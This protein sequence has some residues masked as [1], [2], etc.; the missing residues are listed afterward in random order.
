MV[1]KL[2]TSIHGENTDTPKSIPPPKKNRDQGY[3][4][5]I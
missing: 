5:Y 3:E 1:N 4:V 2:P